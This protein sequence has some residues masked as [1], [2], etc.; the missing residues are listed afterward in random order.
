MRRTL[1][2]FL[3]LA[4]L[5]LAGR[6]LSAQLCATAN[7]VANSSCSGNVA[8]SLTIPILIRLTIDDTSTTITAPN[9]ADYDAG[10]TTTPSTGP[11]AT[12]K[13]NNNW[14]LLV[15]ASS[16]TWTGSGGAR[17]TKPAGDLLWRTSSGTGGTAMS[18]TNVTIGSGTRGA[19]NVVSIFY[20][21]NWT[22]ALDPPGTYTLT[23]IF[24]ATAP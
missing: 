20:N 7:G 1:P 8:S 19:S 2:P 17:A 18:T 11:V 15:R 6:P 5:A 16:A 22:W 21:T 10:H 3:V 12:V 4:L 23:V 24:P 9:Q 13:T 14:T